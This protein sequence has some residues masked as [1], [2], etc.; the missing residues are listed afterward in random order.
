MNFEIGFTKRSSLKDYFHIVF[1][2]QKK[3]SALME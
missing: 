3:K 2:R 1:S